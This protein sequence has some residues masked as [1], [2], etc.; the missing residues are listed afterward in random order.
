MGNLDNQI[1]CYSVGTSAFHTDEEDRVFK[2]LVNRKGYIKRLRRDKDNDN[3]DEI[4]KVREKVKELE[5]ELRSLVDRHEG[6]RTV[7]KEELKPYSVVG[8]FESVLTRTFGIESGKD[9]DKVTKDIVIVQ[10][11]HLS[12]FRDLI[13]YG[14]VDEN[15][16]QYQYLSSSAGQ[17][18][19]KKGVWVKKVL[20]DKHKD[21]LTCGLSVEDIN[22]KGSINI[23]KYLA[24]SA[25]ITG[26][27]DEWLDFNID[28]CI[29]VDDMDVIVNGEVDYIDNNTYEIT[30]KRMD[31]DITATDGVGM[32]LPSV[33]E[34]NFMVRLPFLKGLLAVMSF[35]EIARECGKCKVTDVWGKEWDV[36]EDGIKIIFTKS[37]LKLWKFFDSWDHYKDNFKKF[38]CQA[39]KLNEEEDTFNQGKLTYQF[40]QTL[41][42]VKDDE[43]ESIV[44]STNYTIDNIG[45]RQDVMLRVL[46]ATE[47]NEQKRSYQKCLM[48]YPELLNDAHSKS[49]IK[50]KK[51]AMV[52]DAKMGKLNVNGSYTFVIPDLYSFSTYLFTGEAKPLLNDGEVHCKLNKSGRTGIL[53]SPHLYREWGLAQNKID[54]KRSKYF[55][56]DALYVAN[57]SLLSK[58]IQNDWDG[59]KALVVQDKV[60]LD[61]AERN[62]K[63]DDIVPLYYEMAKAEAQEINSKNIF[64]S[65]V[66]AMGGKIGLYSNS[67]T[68]IF[69]QPN[70]DLRVVAWLCMENNFEID[71]AK[72]LFRPTRPTEIDEIIK[73]YTKGDLP[74]F[75]QFDSRKIKKKDNR[76][77]KEPRVAA[78][79]DS[80]VNR[81]EDLISNK[82]IHFR[83][84][85]GGKFDYKLLMNNPKT[86][87]DDKVIEKY[88]E[89]NEEKRKLIDKNKEE[90]DKN[91]KDNKLYV[92]V[93]IRNELLKINPDPMYVADVLIQ[94]L[95]GV[96]DSSFKSTLWE[97][98]GEEI[99]VNLD[100]NLDEAL[101][102]ED[103]DSKFRKVKRGQVRCESCYE[104]ELK[105]IDRERKRKAR[106]K[107]KISIGQNLAIAE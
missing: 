1:Y 51:K 65:L 71:Y 42:D 76:I 9:M 83:E 54:D 102:C 69:A 55:T 85:A 3:K 96:K 68:K 23:T 7:R 101:E 13:E 46:G 27:S 18:R 56:T 44:K 107:K 30:R 50:A 94:Y 66:L 106:E 48:K 12:V 86:K 60:L 39:A 22:Q 97:S 84:I 98:F 80:T 16:E 43:L 4:K 62:M 11:Y 15:G 8:I 92:Y 17:T 100:K 35:D 26:A 14:F 36:I 82:R 37:Q 32:M 89:L 5:V 75:F 93:L 72:T 87:I 21:S 52:N 38:N 79:T 53:R 81:L 10:S 33:S 31:I 58:L 74:A 104:I 103:C 41:T 49:T 70:P 40:L 67:I 99:E 95:F 59:D 78:K 28:E 90:F 64:N 88:E 19:Q 24:Y 61:V 45:S 34:K 25:L 63:N 77:V 6:V 47:S 2:E 29:V 57:E 105:R 73:Q 91:K 20:W